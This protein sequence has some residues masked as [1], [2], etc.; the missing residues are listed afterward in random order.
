MLLKRKRFP[1]D[2]C[3]IPNDILFRFQ[4][5][6]LGCFR[7]AFSPNGR[8]LA[9]ACTYDNNKTVIKIFNVEDGVLRYT[10]KG[11][12][13]L[14]HDLSWHPSNRFLVS[15]SSDN[16]SKVW[17]VPEVE[18]ND[19]DEEESEKQLLV[20][21]LFHP[22][23]VYSSKFYMDRDTST[24]VIATACFDAKVRVWRVDF[25]NDRYVRSGMTFL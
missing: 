13:N 6:P 10:L 21:T 25:E 1:E 11:H 15:C 4:S 16:T 20:C 18:M 17:R 8:Y 2:E 3:R 24:L 12:K 23:Y 5:A 14:I 22:F 7:L 9:A 19:I